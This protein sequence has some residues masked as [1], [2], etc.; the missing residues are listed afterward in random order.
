MFMCTANA[1]SSAIVTRIVGLFMLVAFVFAG[2]AFAQSNIN[3]SFENSPTGVITDVG[4]GLEGWAF[5]VGGDVNPAPTFEIVEAAQDGDKALA[6]T[7]NNAGANPWGVEA[8]AFPINVTPGVTY[9]YSIWARAAQGGA[10]VSFTVGNQSFQEYGRL[11]NP[12]TTDWQEITFEFTVT[13]S[14]TVIRAPIHFG[15]GA[16]VGNTIYIDNLTIIDPNAGSP[17]VVVEAEDGDL[18]G[19]YETGTDNLGV[20]YINIT[21]D[22][23]ETTG[24]GDHPGANR[25]ASYEVT[26]A[27]AG[28]YDLFAY[29]YVGGGTFNDD[30]F[31][32]A[33]AFGDKDP[34]LADDWV[35]ANQ[36]A[37]AGFNVDDDYVVGLGGV[38]SEEWKW[39][40]LSDNNFNEVPAATF[41]V[42][43]GNLTQTFEIGARENGLLIDRLAFGRSD[44]FFTV[45]NLDNGE[46]G[47]PTMGDGGFELPDEPLAAGLNKFV[48]NIYSPSQTADFEYYW[49]Y[50]IAENAGKWG[51]VEGTRDQ[52]N[53][54]G[55][56]ASYQLAQEN[57]LLYNFHVL[58]WGNQQPGWISN[59]PPEEQVEEIREWFEAVAERYPDMEVVQV[60]NEVLPTHNPPD[61]NNGRANYMDALGGRGDTGYDWVITAFE[62]AREIFPE[63]TRLMLNDYGILGSTGGGQSYLQ[64][65]NLL[66][67]R[68]LIDVIGVQGHA[69]S[70]RPGAP[71]TAVLDMLGATGLPIQVTEMDVDGNP[72]QSPNVTPEQS[73][74]NQLQD[75]QRIFP[76]MWEHP[77]VEGITFWGWRP[78]LWRTDQEAYLVEANGQPRP[79]LVWLQEYLA[80]FTVAVEPEAEV[81]SVMA[82]GNLPNPF[83]GTTRIRYV[84][85]NPADVTLK[86]YDIMGRL[87]ASLVAEPQRAGEHEALFDASG[88][89]SGIYLYRLQ[90]GEQMQVGQM[91]LM[92]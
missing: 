17:A 64:V 75:M 12:V 28:E 30:S 10:Q 66:Q 40:N 59:L 29:V 52:M 7:V 38:G 27:E 57:G 15:V 41:V 36:L 63:G 42:E 67:E 50:V 46:S 11:T 83:S 60:A 71:I 32:Y 85:D 88:L 6:I 77:S 31:F 90:A 8:T 62:M 87:V 80:D 82:V 2:S 25:T 1:R 48:G 43:E 18:G 55:L 84:L 54:G 24:D 14:E 20:S 21:T 26:F 58:L 5:A 47:S 49:N 65:I 86:V 68:N 69:F 44:L 19:E 23:N 92:K 72:N 51:S 70:T 61:G 37:A 45:A 89:A 33:N 81:P 79:A 22:F 78:G 39:V 13:D 3:G 35:I 4:A 34:E 91:V 74:Q 16:N 76:A 53:W 56:D 9:T 73:D